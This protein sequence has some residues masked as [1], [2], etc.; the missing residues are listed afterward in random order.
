MRNF[1]VRRIIGIVILIVLIGTSIYI[2]NYLENK[3]KI[4]LLDQL[5]VNK[6]YFQSHEI[7]GYSVENRKIE[8][9]TFGQGEKNLLFVGGIHGG[10][11]W[12]SVLLAYKFIDYLRIHPSLVPE[13]IKLTIIPSA[14]PDGLYQITGREGFF[15][16]EDVKESQTFGLGRFNAND[17]DLNRNFDCKWQPRSTWKSNPVSAGTSAFSEPESLAI[18]NYV[19]ENNPIAVIFWHSQSNAVYASECE[20]G[21]LPKTLEIMNV[22]SKASGYKAVDSFDAYEVTGDAEGWLASINIPA[23]TVEL[24]THETIEWDK[25]LKGVNALLDYYR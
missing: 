4:D 10:Y 15:K 23:I 8:V 7:I 1:F 20:N 25:N 11:E 19:L 22:Y 16:T 21:I 3:K 12:N 2:F 6:I 14:N 13:N 18:K 5:E 9:Y 24:K 17:V